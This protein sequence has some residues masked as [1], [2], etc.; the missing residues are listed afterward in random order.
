MHRLLIGCRS[1]GVLA[2]LPLPSVEAGVL[3]NESL[4]RRDQES[5]REDPIQGDLGV[6]T[7]SQ[8]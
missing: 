2:V 4:Q 8:A 5:K 7:G 6:P 1:S 3:N